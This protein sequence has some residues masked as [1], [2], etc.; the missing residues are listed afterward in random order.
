MLQEY[1]EVFVAELGDVS[2]FMP[3]DDE[4]KVPIIQGGVGSTVPRRVSSSSTASGRFDRF[5]RT[6]LA[7][8]RSMQGSGITAPGT[9]CSSITT[10]STTSRHRPVR[11]PSRYCRAPVAVRMKPIGTALRTPSRTLASRRTPEREWYINHPDAHALAPTSLVPYIG[12]SR[13]TNSTRTAGA[14]RLS[15]TNPHGSTTSGCC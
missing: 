3:L 13:T 15:S 12:R 5:V 8:S 1:L 4:G 10:R 9:W 11:R 2:R 14:R 7:D 6:A